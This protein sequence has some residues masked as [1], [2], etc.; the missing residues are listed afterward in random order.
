[1]CVGLCQNINAAEVVLEYL[2]QWECKVQSSVTV[3]C[4]YGSATEAA[5]ITGARRRQS[6]NPEQV[7]AWK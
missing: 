6:C 1:M 5:C 7:S 3:I 2:H 4:T